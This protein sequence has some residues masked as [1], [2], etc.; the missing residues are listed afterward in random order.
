MI[1]KEL[2]KHENKCNRKVSHDRENSEPEII[3][4]RVRTKLGGALNLDNHRMCYNK[5]GT[6]ARMEEVNVT[7]NLRDLFPDTKGGSKIDQRYLLTLFLLEMVPNTEVYS[8]SNQTSTME[9][10]A[11]LVN[12]S[13][14]LLLS[15]KLHLRCLN[16]FRMRL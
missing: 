9:L 5:Y 13:Q 2:I 4:N 14:K 10:S 1:I 3:W 7:N 6:W 15:Q 8:L 11:K 12:G 16:G